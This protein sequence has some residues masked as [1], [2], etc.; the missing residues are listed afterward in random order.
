MNTSKISKLAGGFIGTV[1][2][3]DMLARAAHGLVCLA[4]TLSTFLNPANL[5]ASLAAIAVG[6]ASL[7]ADMVGGLIKARI[8][9]LLGTALLPLMM[10]Q[11]YIARLQA[12]TLQLGKLFLGLE[13]RAENLLNY[14]FN[15]QDCASQA[16]QL[17]NCITKLIA[18]KITN[19]I[20]PKI[21]SVFGKLQAEVSQEVFKVGGIMEQQ[22]GRRIRTAEKITAQLSILR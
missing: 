4:S 6:A 20:L 18:K 1:G 14:I 2:K 17:M 12:L 19:K 22:V 3:I 9:Q 15:T 8:N 16:A 13:N 5:L 10:L 11:G 21:D 7:V